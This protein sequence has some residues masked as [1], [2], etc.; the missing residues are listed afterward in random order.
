MSIST[1]AFWSKKFCATC[2]LF[3]NAKIETFFFPFVGIPIHQFLLI[4]LSLLIS[5]SKKDSLIDI[6]SWDISLLFRFNLSEI[7]DF[8]PHTDAL[9]ID[10]A[11]IIN[12]A[13]FFVNLII[14]SRIFSQCTGLKIW[15]SHI[16]TTSN[17]PC[18]LGCRK[19]EQIDSVSRNEGSVNLISLG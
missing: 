12:V 3:S 8:I 17:F 6:I 15:G 7:N 10:P 13:Q 14:S 19:L 18:R 11:W 1:L 2:I 9:W 5:I 16:K 4:N